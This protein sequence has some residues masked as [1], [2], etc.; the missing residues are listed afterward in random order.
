MN[1]QIESLIK[2]G[3]KLGRL[4]YAEI[5][6][7]LSEEMTSPE[8]I[9]N[10]MERFD[11]LGIEVV[12]KGEQAEALPKEE[13]PPLEEAVRPPVAEEKGEKV[14]D[15]VRMYLREIGQ[16]PLLSHEKETA[17]A[18]KIHQN[19]QKLKIIVMESPLVFKEIRNWERLA[20]TPSR[21]ARALIP[22]KRLRLKIQKYTYKKLH[23][24]LAEIVKYLIGI[25]QIQREVVKHNI[26]EARRRRFEHSQKKK[27]QK[28][29]HQ[30]TRLK[31]NPEKLADLIQKIHNLSS[32]IKHSEA[33]IRK[34][35]EKTGLK[36]KD[37][38]SFKRRMQ[39]KAISLS[40]FRK[41]TGLAMKDMD[42]IRKS[43]DNASQRLK[44][45]QH[46]YKMNLEEIKQLSAETKTL[47]NEI[48]LGMVRLIEANLRLVVKIAKKYTNRNLEFLDLVNEGNLGLIKAATKFEY[49]KGF[50]FSTYA[51]WW[52]RQSIN[53]AIADQGGTIRIPIH[54]RAMIS[55]VT[56][57]SRYCRQTYGREAV[58]EEYAKGI[59]LKDEK[60]K[61]IFR[62]M[63]NPVSLSA[64][65]GK[66]EGTPLED[67]V[68]DQKEPSPVLSTADEIRREK[69]KKVL[70]TLPSRELQVISYRFGIDSGYPLTLEEVG[71]LFHITRERVRQIESKA[72]R[73][74]R[75]P[76]RS[77]QLKPYL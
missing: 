34:L 52:I 53:R 1:K 14:T 4:T 75:H 27:T 36:L 68:E 15:A 50:K 3:Q 26:Q 8:E 77:R 74:L 10:L 70:K 45:I 42:Q 51:T 17:L 23:Q 7:H 39:S 62:I 59:N 11:N 63:R 44:H 69:I 28:L 13:L 67:F 49:K 76:V 6:K 37:I 64:M 5:N 21:A 40:R 25:S 57:L 43:V 71:R 30:I 54:M 48:T 61:S 65:V 24:S 12:E 31:I 20:R 19:Q 60:V 35:E 29:H 56:K 2:R 47:E 22:Q 72:I 32:R 38:R 33:E 18:T 41:E 9:D 58:L 46:A 55:K 66:E 16:F 73:K